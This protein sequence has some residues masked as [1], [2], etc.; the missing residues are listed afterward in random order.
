MS[1]RLNAGVVLG[2][3]LVVGELA[4]GGIRQRTAILD[5]L[6]KLPRARVAS[7]EEV[8]ALVEQEKLWGRGI[9]YVD[10]HLLASVLLTPG[11]GLWTRDRRLVAAAQAIGV[12]EAPV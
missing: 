8:L 9:S 5:T 2:H 12:P 1:A 3:I 6:R 11:S 7:H 10:A 4:M